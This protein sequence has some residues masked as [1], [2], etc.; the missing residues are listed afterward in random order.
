M[1]D[2]QA[3]PFLKWAGGKARILPELLK[4]VPK[5]FD[6]YHEPFVG[7]GALF[8]ALQ[9]ERA[10][11]SD[12]NDNLICVYK[13][14]Q[15]DSCRIADRLEGFAERHNREFYLEMRA[16]LADWTG[17]FESDNGFAALFIYLNKTCFNGLYRVNKNGQFNVPIGKR[18]DGGKIDIVNRSGLIAAHKALQT[19][20]ILRHDKYQ[21]DKRKGNNFYYF[22]PPYDGQFSSYTSG[23]FDQRDQTELMWRALTLGIYGNKVMLS[24]ADTP[25]IRDLYKNFNIEGI[26][27]PRSIS[28]DGSKRKKVGELIITNY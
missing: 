24:N 18:S 17:D 12:I 21:S 16:S 5:D 27:A 23:G 28:A 1:S 26:Q 3:K 10:V 11:L 19:A 14:L 7:G 15:I 8:F 22:D 13:T 6:V 4:R 9:P 2:I 20:T 25:F